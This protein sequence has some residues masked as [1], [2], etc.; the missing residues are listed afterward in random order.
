MKR[1]SSV[2]LMGPKC[3]AECNLKCPYAR[4]YRDMTAE[5]RMQGDDRRLFTRMWLQ[6]PNSLGQWKT[7]KGFDAAPSRKK[8][9]CL[10][11]DFTS[12]RLILDV[13]PLE[14]YENKYMLF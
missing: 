9:L 13:C 6:N 8:K 4:S 7:R 12:L 14:L 5:G 11:L 1:L 2:V 10:Y 3:M